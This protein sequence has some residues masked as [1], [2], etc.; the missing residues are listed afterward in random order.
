MRRPSKLFPFL[1]AALAS[2]LLPIAAQAGCGCDHPPPDWSL[3]QPPFGSSGRSLTIHA[4]GGSFVVGETYQVDFAGVTASGQAWA[5]DSLDVE[6]PRGVPRGPVALHVTGP[7]YDRVYDEALFTALP[8]PRR[9]K[10]REGVFAAWN[11]K[12]AVGAD[13][14]LYLPLNLRRVKDAMQFTLAFLDLPLAFGAED[15]VI[16]NA[17]GVDLTLFTSDVDDPTQRQWGSYYG[18]TVEG[19]SGLSGDYFEGQVGEADDDDGSGAPSSV[20]NLFTYWRHE[21][22]SYADAHAPGGSHE[23]NESGYHPD[24]TLHI[25]HDHLVI[26]ISGWLRD[27]ADPN[28][29]TPLEPGKQPAKVAWISIKTDNPVELSASASLVDDADSDAAELLEEVLFGEDDD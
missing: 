13:G 25:D 10:E 29:G 17:D 16:Y 2:A 11:Y 6:V 27:P 14:T 12:A 9:V 20:S 24:G 7:G 8:R 28:G 23:V 26:A 3:V 21:F 5:A 15:V 22:H 19:D 18:W 1:L 4:D